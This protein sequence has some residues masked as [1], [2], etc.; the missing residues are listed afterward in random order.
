MPVA[1]LTTILEFWKKAQARLDVRVQRLL[2]HYSRAESMVLA[3]VLTDLASEKSLTLRDRRRAEAFARDVFRAVDVTA[4]TE[5]PQLLNQSFQIGKDLAGLSLGENLTP[6]SETNKEAMT[7]LAENLTEDLGKA[8][9]TVGRTVQDIYRHE[10][11]RVALGN[12]PGERPVGV[13]A[14]DL[15]K[16]LR[17]QG[18]TSFV[19]RSGRRWSLSAYAEMA[20]I[21][22]THEAINVSNLN[23]L[24]Q[25]GIDLIEINRVK[26]PC[27]D[28]LPFNGQTFSLTGRAKGYPVL[29]RRPPFHGRCRHFVFASPKALEERRASGWTPSETE[30]DLEVVA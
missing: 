15:E 20:T 23:L 12:V 2:L 16:A 30:K 25:R 5:I 6:L 27:V 21:T 1:L 17:D 3:R 28:C 26:G 4:K 14:Y 7:L 8:T 29:E 22:T 24:T 18:L 10:A 11:L 9:E 13:A 19:D